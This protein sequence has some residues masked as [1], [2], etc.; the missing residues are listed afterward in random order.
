MNE[1][2]I[3][4]GIRVGDENMNRQCSEFH[5]TSVRH[6]KRLLYS[7]HGGCA[8]PEGLGAKSAVIRGEA[9][10]Q[11]FRF[12]SHIHEPSHILVFKGSL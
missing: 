6:I 4:G 12:H 3:F 7:T 11:D 2:L 8:A 5:L 9:D 10:G 1:G